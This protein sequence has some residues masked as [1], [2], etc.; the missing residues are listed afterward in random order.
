MRII[1][2]LGVRLMVIY[3]SSVV[4]AA[5]RNVDGTDGVDDSSL[6]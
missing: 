2:V 5:D 4:H 3:R 6:R 1:S